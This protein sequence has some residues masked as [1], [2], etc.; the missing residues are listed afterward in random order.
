MNLW[1]KYSS[2]TFM[3]FFLWTVLFCSATIILLDL[4]QNWNEFKNDIHIALNYYESQFIPFLLMIIPFSMFV[5]L[6]LSLNR[7]KSNNELN[8]LLISSK[9]IWMMIRSIFISGFVLV[10]FWLFM[11][12]YLWPKYRWQHLSI[13]GGIQES[14]SQPIKT[15]FKDGF[16][17][18]EECILKKR[19]CNGV[20]LHLNNNDKPVLFPPV[21][22]KFEAG[23]WKASDTFIQKLS[24][25]YRNIYNKLIQK[26]MHQPMQLLFITGQI[27]YLTIGELYDLSKK[28][29]KAYFSF[30]LRVLMVILFLFFFT[31]SMLHSFLKIKAK[32]TALCSM[33]FLT[34]L[35]MTSLLMSLV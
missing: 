26:N 34:F 11:Y 19:E 25:K 23:Y 20:V 9:N 17:F 2:K 18:I 16:I 27:N 22:L 24:F 13:Q 29:E 1:D 4:G 6:A 28:T 33:Y 14:I 5:S 12:E 3:M 15:D 31:V 32:T 30:I 21:N 7:F 35:L 10:V 8:I